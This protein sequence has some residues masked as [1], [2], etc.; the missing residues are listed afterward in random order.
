MKILYV[1]TIGGTMSFFKN[2][3]CELIKDGHTVDIATNEND[4]PVPDYYKE[5]GCK[6]HQIDTSRSPLSKSNITAYKQLK[7]LV[8]S[9]EYDIVHCHTP[10][11]AMITRLACRK[12]RKKGTKVFY[13]AHGFHFYKGAP[14]L[15]WLIYYP[16]EKICS[17]FTDVLITINKE[18]YALAQK[19]MKSKKVEYVPGVGIEVEKFANPGVTREQKREELGIPQNVKLII[20]V[21]ELNKNKNHETVIRAIKD[22]DVYYIIAGVG[23][24]QDYLQSL[25][26]ELNLTNR[27]KLLGY[28]TDVAELYAAADVFVFPSFRE[29]LGLAAIE[30]MGFGLPLVVADNRGTRDFCEKGVNGIL[31]NPLCVNEFQKSIENILNDSTLREVMRQANIEKAKIFDVE[32]IN[33]K[34]LKIYFS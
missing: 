22:L 1:T 19:K 4:R 25:I 33:D 12:V 17:Y 21:G 6:I 5:W 3:L 9:G 7:K 23:D 27:V 13:T 8:E 24:L 11:A 34:M 10:V 28:R 32:F 26:N 30:G 20:S 29:G 18:D 31:C 15:N 2:F 16:I 14:K